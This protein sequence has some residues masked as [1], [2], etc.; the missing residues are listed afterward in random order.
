MLR[1]SEWLLNEELL[2]SIDM[3]AAIMRSGVPPAIMSQAHAVMTADQFL[4]NPPPEAKGGYALGLTAA[5]GMRGIYFHIAEALGL[6][7]WPDAYKQVFGRQ[8][9]KMDW[10]QTDIT[11]R[12]LNGILDKNDRMIVFFLPNDALTK[13]RFTREEVEYF[14]R[15]PDKIKRVIFVLGAYDLVDKADYQKLVASNRN[16]RQRRDLAVSVLRQPQQHRKPGE[17]V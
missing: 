13:G 8:W 1:F 15:N 3:S 11:D 16:Q 4:E 6:I 10:N 2:R 9:A 7:K 17:P 14:Q 5:G 12:F